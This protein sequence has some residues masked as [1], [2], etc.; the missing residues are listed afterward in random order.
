[1]NFLANQQIPKIRLYALR[2]PIANSSKAIS[3]S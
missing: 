3:V 1:M 2:L